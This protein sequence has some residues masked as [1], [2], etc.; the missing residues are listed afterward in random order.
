MFHSAKVIKE[1]SNNWQIASI[2]HDTLWI[3]LSSINSDIVERHNYIFLFLTYHADY[4]GLEILLWNMGSPLFSDWCEC[5]RLLYRIPSSDYR[6]LY[7]RLYVTMQ[8]CSFDMRARQ[9]MD[10]VYHNLS[11]FQFMPSKVIIL[12]SMDCHSPRGK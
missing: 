10:R 8:D 7:L 6:N 9:S 2:D 5:I 12:V 4:T 11:D 3:Y 1:Y